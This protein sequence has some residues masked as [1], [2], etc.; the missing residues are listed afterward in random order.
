MENFSSSL[1]QLWTAAQNVLFPS[2]LFMLFKAVYFK[3]EQ[4]SFETILV[5]HLKIWKQ[6]AVFCNINGFPALQ[7]LW[8]LPRN[9]LP[10]KKTNS[11]EKTK[12]IAFR[13][14]VFIQRRCKSIYSMQSSCSQSLQLANIMQLNT[15]YINVAQIYWTCVYKCSLKLFSDMFYWKK[16]YISS[17]FSDIC[18][19]CE[20]DKKIIDL[21][22]HKKMIDINN[23]LK[24]KN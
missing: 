24:K 12:N 17:L 11:S 6:K 18:I 23:S 20:V 5:R 7:N 13:E 22:H 1:K 14:D 3:I 10:K 4:L 21:F 8:C 2:L 16:C 9:S 19:N 15:L